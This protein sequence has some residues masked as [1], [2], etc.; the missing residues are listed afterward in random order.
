MRPIKSLGG[1][2]PDDGANS[3]QVQIFDHT[4][5]VNSLQGEDRREEVKNDIIDH[6]KDSS[7]EELRKKLKN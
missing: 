7:H 5:R 3:F 4:N 6:T 2:S 1:K